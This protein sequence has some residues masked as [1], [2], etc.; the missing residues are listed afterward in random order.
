M[1][2]SMEWLKR[3]DHT[4]ETTEITD[5]SFEVWQSNAP[6]DNCWCLNISRSTGQE[7]IAVRG[8]QNLRDTVEFIKG[9]LGE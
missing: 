7:P 4:T 3:S 1:K 8:L 9:F 5:P 6:T 2:E